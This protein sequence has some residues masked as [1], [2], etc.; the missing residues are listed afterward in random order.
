[1][2]PIEVK[3]N[4]GKAKLKEGIMLYCPSHGPGRVVS[5]EQKEV[6]GEKLVFCQMEFSRD[7]IKLYVPMDRMKDMGIRV[8]MSHDFAKKILD[9][10]LNKPAKSAK[11]VWTKRIQEYEMKLYSGSAIFIAEVV[12]D[13]FAGMKDPN[14]SY[15][16]RLLFD[17]AFGYLVQEMS[18]ALHSSIEETNKTVLDILNSNCKVTHVDIERSDDTDGD[19]DDGD[20][21]KL[22]NEDN[23]IKD[24]MKETR[25]KKVA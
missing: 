12:R 3:L 22:E 11:G 17:K 6:L 8:I 14:K 2:T 9:T 5:I 15:G 4:G 20:F 10:V 13:L 1:M 7:G 18:I 16:E 23:F 21:D 19:F 25:K 24:E